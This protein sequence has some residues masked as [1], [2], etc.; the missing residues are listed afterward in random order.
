MN[1]KT[2][3]KE[4]L[5]FYPHEKWKLLVNLERSMIMILP[6][7]FVCVFVPVSKISQNL[8]DMF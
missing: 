8:L 6:V 4:N 2:E 7:S 1:A 5:T 3:M